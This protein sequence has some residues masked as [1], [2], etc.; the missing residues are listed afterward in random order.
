MSDIQ[1]YLDQLK[2]QAAGSETV[3]WKSIQ[4]KLVLD[5]EN[6]LN[7]DKIDP[8]EGGSVLDKGLKRP[9]KKKFLKEL[10]FHTKPGKS[11][12]VYRDL[13]SAFLEF[14]VRAD[15]LAIKVGMT[16]EEF[17]EH[18]NRTLEVLDTRIFETNV[19]RYETAEELLSDEKGY[20]EL[21]V[22]RL[23]YK[24]AVEVLAIESAIE[25]QK[26]LASH[27]VDLL[28]LLHDNDQKG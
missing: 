26:A 6:P 15:L 14:R 16:S 9:S 10:E 24:K 2:E 7:L 5:E 23:E 22:L 20:E 17:L 25:D 1:S 11:I 4:R 18:I 8:I 3:D 12:S 27:K 28:S 21:E 19:V 13:K